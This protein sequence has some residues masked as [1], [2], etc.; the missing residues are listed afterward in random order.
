MRVLLFAAT[1]PSLSIFAV[2]MPRPGSAPSS[3]S[4]FTIS[5]P[6][7]RSALLSTSTSAIFVPMPWLATLPP[8]SG[9]SV[10]ILRLS[11][12]LFG[13]SMSGMFVLV[14]RSLALLSIFGVS[15]AVAD[16]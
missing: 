6:E 8:T 5:M 12:L 11:T 15:V 16:L 4:L 2:S 10:L 13:L 14:P 7:L 1:C 3:I 9:M